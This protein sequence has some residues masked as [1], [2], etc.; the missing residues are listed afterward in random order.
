MDSLKKANETSVIL[1]V[2]K[3]IGKAEHFKNERKRINT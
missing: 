2:N 3:G 1:S